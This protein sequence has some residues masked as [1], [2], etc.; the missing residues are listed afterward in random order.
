MAALKESDSICLNSARKPPPDT[1]HQ[2]GLREVDAFEHLFATDE[3]ARP[4]LEIHWPLCLVSQI[5]WVD[6]KAR[7]SGSVTGLSTCTFLPV[8][9][10]L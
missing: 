9:C 4:R 10:K 7:A 5:A 1:R 6:F 3:P 2:T 8:A